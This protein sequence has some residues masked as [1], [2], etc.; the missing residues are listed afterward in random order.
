MTSVKFA[1]VVLAAGEGRRA[2]GY[3][4]L[5]SFGKDFRFVDRIIWAA[6]SVCEEIRVVGGA[7]FDELKEHVD[8]HHAGVHLIQNT[9]WKH[10]G[11]FSS[12]QK[13]LRGVVCPCFIHPADIPGPQEGT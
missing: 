2:G 9:N 11:M 4:P 12:V 1:A 3:N 6:R 7:C 5:F 13:G 8:A 10:G